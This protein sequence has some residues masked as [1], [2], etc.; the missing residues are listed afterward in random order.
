MTT[1]LLIATLLAAGAAGTPA[2]RVLNR[3]AATVNGEVLT[4]RD[5]EVR[6][7]ASLERADALPP[8]PDRDRARTA[9]LRAAL[10]QL[11]AERLFDGQAAALG[12]DVGAGE[13]DAAIDEIKRRNRLDDAALDQALAQQGM[14]RAAFRKAVKRDLESMRIL[15]VKV[16]NRVKV[17]DEDVKAYW[18]SHPQEFRLD[19]EVRVRHLF[20][21]LP[22]T[23]GAE[24][25]ARAQAKAARLVARARAGEDFAALARAESEGP[26]ARD[27]GELGWLRRGQIQAELEKVAFAL[28]PG[29]VSDVVRTR[30]G[31][32]ILKVEER[33][34]GG[35]RPFDEVKEEIRGRLM[36]DQA[37]SYRGQFVAEL[38]KEA[39]I[40]VRLPELR[41][42]APPAPAG[43]APPATGPRS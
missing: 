15:Q 9:A 20:L 32:Q 40:D 17:T 18:Q 4:L 11:V 22:P 3:V 38:R 39:T 23:A 8:G 12:V 6:A 5:V 16:R 21:A 7:G 2:P 27:G 26:S 24:D 13:V 10:D 36:N 41:D 42:A 25:E 28:S 34:G 19:E 29:G 31:L 43:A 35:P 30:A 1:T 37:E 14:D 33:R